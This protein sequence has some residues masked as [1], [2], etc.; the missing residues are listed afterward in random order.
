MKYLWLAYCRTDMTTAIKKKW[1]K[2]LVDIQHGHYSA[3][4]YHT[5]DKDV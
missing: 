5:K 3:L 1:G 4:E 2:G